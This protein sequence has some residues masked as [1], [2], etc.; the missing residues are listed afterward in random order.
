MTVSPEA[1]VRAGGSVPSTL[2]QSVATEAVRGHEPISGKGS[3]V[4]A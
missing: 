4:L 2:C 3:G 1:M